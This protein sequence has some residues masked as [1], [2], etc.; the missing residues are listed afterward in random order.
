MENCTTESA[1]LSDAGMPPDVRQF[2]FDYIDSVE[3]L[4]VLL[5]LRSRRERA[6]SV[7]E[8]SQ[9]FRSSPQSIESRLTLLKEN[10]FIDEAGGQNPAAFRFRSENSEL[11]SLLMKIADEYKRRRQ[12]VLELIFS[13]L[14]KGRSFA[15]AFLIRKN[16]NGNGE[17]N[18]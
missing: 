7:A 10:N 1:G 18:G 15:D 17:S 9:E 12:S 11:D 5:F 14:K 6:W 4:E 2:I 3:Q 16:P 8:L 13:P